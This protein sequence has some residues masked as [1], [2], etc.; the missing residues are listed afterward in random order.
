MN[1]CPFGPSTASFV[2]TNTMKPVVKQLRSCGYMS[3]IYLDNLMLEGD[4]YGACLINLMNTKNLLESLGFV[5]NKE[6]SNFHPNTCCKFLGYIFS[7]K[8]FHINLCSQKLLKI[9]RELN[10]FQILKRC[11]IRDFA[12][13]IGLLT[14]A[15]PAVDYSWLYTK[16][17]GRYKFKEGPTKL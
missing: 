3:T 8:D 17:L 9:K 2:F 14:S 15:C 13:L 4:S 5:I 11:K 10:C 16:N 1:L 7:T 6:K 12:R